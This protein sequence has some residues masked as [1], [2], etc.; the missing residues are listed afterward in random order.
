MMSRKEYTSMV[1]TYMIALLCALPIVIGLDLLISAYVSLLVL[2][3]IDIIIFLIA[4]VVGFI[5]VDRRK[6]KIAEKREEFLK[7]KEN[8][9]KTE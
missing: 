6:K 1:K 5:I 9:D 8:K 4:A 3:I 7:N 2:V